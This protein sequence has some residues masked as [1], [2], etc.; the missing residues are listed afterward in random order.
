MEATLARRVRIAAVVLLVVWFLSARLQSVIPLW[1]PFLVY[2]GLEL[3]F[4]V[5]G[6]RER[7]AGP[8]A[9]G[10]AP[11]TTDVEELGGDD[12]LEPVLVEIEGE[13]VWLPAAGKTDEEVEELV[14]EARERL[15]RGEPAARDAP[16][17]RPRAP[18]RHRLLAR[19]E[20]LAV[21]GVLALLLFV[22]VPD[23]GWSGL[24]EADREKTETLLSSEAARIAGHEARVRCDADG[25]AVGIVQHADGLAEVGGSNAYLTPELC[26]RLYR[27]AFE[28]DEGAFS[29]TAR[30]IAVLAHEAWHLHGESDEGVTNCYAFQSGVT[31][32]QRLGLSESTAAR[33]MRQQLADNATYGRSAREYLVPAECRNGGEL[34]LAPE[35]SRF[36]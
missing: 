7:G 26:H 11:Q 16:V 2:A 36:P 19:L 20:G 29:Q 17:P 30:A 4:L 25:D 13:D 33:M 15:R 22:L 1:L 34:D 5:G 14:E 28:N 3:N 27:L 9:R 6:L 18:R 21:V 31:L 12:W 23:G 35:S 8:R 32:G 24:D 10:R